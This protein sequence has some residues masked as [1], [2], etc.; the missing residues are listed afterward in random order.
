MQLFDY[1]HHKHN[2]LCEVQLRSLECNEKPRSM[3]KHVREDYL[4]PSTQTEALEGLV[5]YRLSP[6]LCNTL[7]LSDLSE[8]NQ[9]CPLTPQS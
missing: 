2:T 5:P 9:A 7:T 6:S 8:S 3:H 4:K 1:Q